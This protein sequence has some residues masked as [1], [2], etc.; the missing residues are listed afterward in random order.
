MVAMVITMSLL[1]TMAVMTHYGSNNA[2]GD[3]GVTVVTPTVN[4]SG[5]R[6]PGTAWAPYRNRGAT[7]QRSGRDDSLGSWGLG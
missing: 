5:S 4:S 7:P 3:G 6:V 2:D 1:V